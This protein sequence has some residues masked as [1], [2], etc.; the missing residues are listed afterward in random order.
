[1]HFKIKSIGGHNYLYLIRNAWV[2]GKVKQVQQRY[3][4][5]PEQVQKLLDGERNLH[6]RSTS[7]RSS[8]GT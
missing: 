6:I 7:S 4:G 8:T 2:D 3:V 5:S 1:V